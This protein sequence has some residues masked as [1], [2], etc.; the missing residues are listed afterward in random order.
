M[1]TRQFL[2]Y[3]PSALFKPSLNNLPY[4]MLSS[5]HRLS[6]AWTKVYLERCSR[7]VTIVSLT[8]EFDENK[9]EASR[10]HCLLELRMVYW[11]LYGLTFG[12]RKRTR[13]QTVETDTMH[14]KYLWPIKLERDQRGSTALRVA[15][16]RST[17]RA[18]PSQA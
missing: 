10:S 13:R 14:G 16:H 5:T 6:R 12:E 3:L 1:A 15:Y 9:E 8:Q 4:H 17:S 7:I 18:R 11:W 2:T